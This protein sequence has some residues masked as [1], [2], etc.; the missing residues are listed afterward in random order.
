M[1]LPEVLPSVF[2][3]ELVLLAVFSYAA[4]VLE[5]RCFTSKMYTG[6]PRLSRRPVHCGYCSEVSFE[7]RKVNAL[8]YLPVY[9]SH[10]TAPSR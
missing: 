9:A 1:S 10:R 8:R 6:M 2:A 5:L 4:I 7:R 3:L